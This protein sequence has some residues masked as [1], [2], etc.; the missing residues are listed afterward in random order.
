MFYYIFYPEVKHLFHEK[1]MKDFDLNFNDVFQF[2]A[3]IFRY[4]FLIP[5]Q[6]N[7]R[8]TPTQ[9]KEPKTTIVKID[10]PPSLEPPQV[11]KHQQEEVVDQSTTNKIEK[12]MN[13]I[14]QEKKNIK[15]LF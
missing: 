1:D 9:P 7:K 15:Q 13:M 4:C 8:I 10:P 11:K 12:A 3:I 2:P 5:S 14:D 6:I